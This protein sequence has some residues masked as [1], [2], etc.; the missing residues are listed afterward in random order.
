MSHISQKNHSKELIEP[1]E[2]L[3]SK[4][5][6]TLFKKRKNKEPLPISFLLSFRRLQVLLFPALLPLLLRA[7]A[8]R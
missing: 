5:S 6:V 4:L 1:L 3:L 8:V 7:R 2:N